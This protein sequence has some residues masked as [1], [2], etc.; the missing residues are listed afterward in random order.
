MA[1]P[2]GDSGIGISCSPPPALGR[3]VG[4]EP[5]GKNGTGGVRH[6]PTLACFLAGFDPSM[7][8]PPAPISDAGA[9]PSWLAALSS[10][11]IC[12]RIETQFFLT[13]GDFQI[14]AERRY[15]RM[16]CGALCRPPLS[17]SLSL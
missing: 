16:Y 7:P 2:S 14:G 4:E 9:F 11:L 15:L 17:L 8:L 13:P 12:V 6:C 5:E 10:I 1:Y 3:S